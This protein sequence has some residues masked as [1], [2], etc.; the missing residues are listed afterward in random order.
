MRMVAALNSWPRSPDVPVGADDGPFEAP[1]LAVVPPPV[2][3]LSANIATAATATRLTRCT[4]LD[5]ERTPPLPVQ[6][7]PGI[8]AGGNTPRVWRLL[9]LGG[10]R[11]VS[12]LRGSGRRPDARGPW[13]PAG[14]SPPGTR[15]GCPTPWPSNT[16]CG[17]HTPTAGS[18]ARADHP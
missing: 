11:R 9:V 8:R 3:A 15:P 13:R 18:T 7:V 14:G 2:H 6:V 17:T 4:L 5:I 16:G 12:F 1:R 10:V